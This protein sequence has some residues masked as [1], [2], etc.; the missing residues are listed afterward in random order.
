MD[1][2][3]QKK[4]KYDAT[5]TNNDD[6]DVGD[7]ENEVNGMFLL[8]HYHCRCHEETFIQLKQLDIL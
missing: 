6:I 8:N 3:A 7:V 1:E 5:E 4:G 2:P